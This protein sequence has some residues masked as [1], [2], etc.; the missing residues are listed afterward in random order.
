MTGPMHPITEEDLH[1]YVDGLLDEARRAVVEAYLEA[2]PETAERIEAYARQR[3]GLRELFPDR[4]S[5]PLPSQLIFSRLA[6]E[7]LRQRRRPWAAIAATIA[8]L[9]VGGTGGWFLGSRPPGGIA[10]FTQEA[11]A[12]YQVYAVDKRRPVELSAAQES[13]LR[14]WLSNR[15]NR[16]VVVPDLDATGY[17]LLGGR[18]VASEHGPAA[19]LV[20]E[21][22]AGTRLT[23]YLRPIAA[24]SPSPIVPID[25]G[26]IDGCAWIDRSIG[27]SLIAAEPYA[28]LLELSR[29]VRQEVR[30]SG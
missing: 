5:D 30:S 28:K 2:H 7:R 11:A 22:A 13:E 29:Y 27:Y 14:R 20:Y 15:L 8:A 6:E 21:N 26:A 1:A 25:I 19:L 10:A 17:Q 9:A 12:S 3:A 16:P 24:D 18:L 23:I 4:S